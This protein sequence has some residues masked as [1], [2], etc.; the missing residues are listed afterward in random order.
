[1][2]NQSLVYFFAKSNFGD[3]NPDFIKIGYTGT[4]LSLRKAALQTGS[5]SEIWAMGVLP[6]E[7]EDEARR[8]ERR[9]HEHFGGFRARGEWFYATPR[10]IQYIEDYAVQYTERFTEDVPPTSDKE[11]IETDVEPTKSEEAIEFGD[12]LK[13]CRERSKPKMTQ[14][15]VA[16]IVGYSRGAIA[17]IEQGRGMPGQEL[18]EALIG[19]FGEPLDSTLETK[20]GILA[21]RMEDGTWISEN[22]GIDTFIEVIK[23]IGIEKVKNLGKYEAKIPL[24]ADYED[25]NKAQRKVETDTGT[26]YVVSGTNTVTKKKI[27][28]N[29]ADQLKL[30]MVVFANPRA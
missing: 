24:V 17:I 14:E 30:D 21:V 6:F 22:T 9:I 26:F 10:I 4:E 8:E 20:F 3:T 16:E 13:E 28:D 7:A 5:E 11:V 29:I 1:M 27:L 2:S 25:P 18:R 19:L 15:Q 23:K 12:W